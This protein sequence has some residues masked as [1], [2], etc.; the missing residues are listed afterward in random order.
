LSGSAALRDQALGKL[1]SWI[2]HLLSPV[3]TPTNHPGTKLI[4]PL[5]DDLVSA[6]SIV[7]IRRGQGQFR[8]WAM[9]VQ[10]SPE[11]ATGWNS[12]LKQALTE[13]KHGSPQDMQTDGFPG[14]EIHGPSASNRVGAAL[15]GSW[16]VVGSGPSSLKVYHDLLQR[17]KSSQR[18][19]PVADSYWLDAEADLPELTNAIPLPTWLQG[20][21]LQW[22]RVHLSLNSKDNT[23]R[24]RMD[25]AYAQPVQVSLSPWKVPKELIHDPLVSFTAM[26]GAAPWLSRFAILNK[27]QVSPLPYELF[28]WAQADI[29]FQTFAAV[30]SPNASNQ[31][32]KI[33]QSLPALGPSNIINRLP[34]SVMW[35][36]NRAELRFKGLP[37]VAPYLRPFTTRTEGDFIVAGL[38]APA[39]ASNAP[40]ELFQQFVSRTNVIYYDWELTQA[41]LQ[42][43]FPLSQL[44]TTIIPDLVKP[45]TDRSRASGTL[46]LPGQEWLTALA[47]LLGQTITEITRTGPQEFNLVR[48]S[49]CGFTG[50]E[51]ILL[52]DLVADP[53][54]GTN[55]HALPP[56]M[57]SAGR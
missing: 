1:A 33:A 56:G 36:S 26:Q 13:L 52:A 24:T 28:V 41:R 15:A 27:L 10:L 45:V 17:I 53:V 43:W 54:Q 2:A 3:N 12:Q 34:D 19:V 9:A 18:P 5:L 30:P 31:L 6:E 37:F 25:M 42:Q 44:Y 48:R 4:R 47:P 11:R 50:F 20:P 8:D 38:F 21:T 46:S 57:P 39:V 35:L 7:E 49:D 16:V 14:W 32:Q 23:I 40:P 29:P 51:L 22:P 55:R